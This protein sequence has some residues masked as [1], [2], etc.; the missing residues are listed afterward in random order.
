M[1]MCIYMYV[2]FMLEVYTWRKN[3]GVGEGELSQVGHKPSG[4][5]GVGT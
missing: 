5:N 3:W 1:Y 2:H 4:F